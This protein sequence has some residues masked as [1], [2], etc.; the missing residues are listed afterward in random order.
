[1]NILYMCMHVLMFEYVLF[2]VYQY[3][4]ILLTITNVFIRPQ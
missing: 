1:M 3:S 2:I 4:N